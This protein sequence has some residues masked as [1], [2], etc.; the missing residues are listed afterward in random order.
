MKQ[1]TATLFYTLMKKN[2]WIE[3]TVDPQA[4]E[5]WQDTEVQSELETLGSEIGFE[6]YPA[7][8]KVYLIPTQDNDLFL[9]NNVD[10]RTDIKADN[11]VKLRHLYLLNYLAIYLLYLLFRGEG[12]NAV[13]LPFITKEK[14]IE[15][16]NQH[17]S[18]V[19]RKEFDEGSVQAEYSESFLQ[20]ANMWLG[21]TEGEPKSRKM[22]EKYGCINRLLGKFR[23]DGLFE[24]QDDIIHPTDK[25]KDLMPYFLRKSRIT[26]IN[27]WIAQEQEG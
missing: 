14:L 3:R 12:S 4:W 26:D 18:N 9:K 25:L 22:A 2:G 13:A 8:G 1:E 6:M 23:A 21:M 20:L 10:Y 24:D 11:D 7:G 27:H 17:C 19:T 15:Q 16:F 5:Y